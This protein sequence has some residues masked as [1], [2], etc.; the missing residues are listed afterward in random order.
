MAVIGAPMLKSFTLPDGRPLHR[1]ASS[2]DWRDILLL[3]LCKLGLVVNRRD[4][5]NSNEQPE[6]E[7]KRSRMLLGIMLECS[8]VHEVGR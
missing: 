2:L 4:E 8:F 7:G 5:L 3:V 6:Q 1:R